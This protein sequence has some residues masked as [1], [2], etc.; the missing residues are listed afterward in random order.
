MTT[1]TGLPGVRGPATALLMRDSKHEGLSEVTSG[2]RSPHS[3]E[4]PRFGVPL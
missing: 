2:D 1:F 3:R 4:G